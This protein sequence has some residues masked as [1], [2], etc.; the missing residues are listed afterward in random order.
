MGRKQRGRGNMKEPAVPGVKYWSQVFFITGC[1]FYKH[2]LFDKANWSWVSAL[3][4]Q[5]ISLSS[6]G[7]LPGYKSLIVAVR[8]RGQRP[9][10][11]S[12]YFFIYKFLTDTTGTNTVCFR[13]NV[14]VPANHTRGSFTCFWRSSDWSEAWRQNRMME[15]SSRQSRSLSI[16]LGNNVFQHLP[17]QISDSTLITPDRWIITCSHVH[18]SIKVTFQRL[19]VKLTRRWIV[20]TFRSVCCLQT[21]SSAA[22]QS[23]F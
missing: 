15:Q 10:N 22:S 16:D 23:S 1:R 17:L 19:T 7:L 9:R 14:N 5:T 11:D 2:I 4:Q 3:R 12:C 18:S 20:Q 21:C 13:L 6:G 8:E